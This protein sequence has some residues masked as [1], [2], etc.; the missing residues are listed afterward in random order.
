MAAMDHLR[1][2]GVFLGISLTATRENCD[3]I[4]GDEFLDLV[5]DKGAVYGRSFHYVPIA[6]LCPE[7]LW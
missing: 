7:I 6:L 5:I 4:F 3:E 2:N 1:D